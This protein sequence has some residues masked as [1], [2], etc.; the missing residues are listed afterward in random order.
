M[1]IACQLEKTQVKNMTPEFSRGTATLRIIGD[2]IKNFYIINFNILSSWDMSNKLKISFN[3]TSK[4]DTTIDFAI[5]KPNYYRLELVRPDKRK[6]YWVN[7]FLQQNEITEVIVKESDSEP[8][9]EFGG[10]LAPI[11]DYLLKKDISTSKNRQPLILS[12]MSKLADWADYDSA[13]IKGLNA[14]LLFLKNYPSFNVLPQWFQQ[15]ER[16]Q[17]IYSYAQ[18]KLTYVFWKLELPPDELNFLDTMV[19]NNPDAVLSDTYYHFLRSYFYF[20][21]AKVW[22][23]RIQDYFSLSHDEKMNAQK[24]YVI[25]THEIN[26][27]ILDSLEKE[28]FTGGLKLAKDKLSNDIMTKLAYFTSMTD[29]Y[30]IPTPSHPAVNSY[31]FY[32]EN[33]KNHLFDSL[34]SGMAA[35]KFNLMEGEKIEFNN[36]LNE[37]SEGIKISQLKGKV[38]LLNFWFPGCRPCIESIPD[39]VELVKEFKDKDF[40]LVSIGTRA[41]KDACF[42]FAKEYNMPGL[43]LFAEYNR[44][45]VE[46]YDLVSY[47]KFILIDKGGRIMNLKPPRPGNQELNKMIKL[48]L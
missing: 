28:H 23:Q 10:S 41:D 43:L 31:Q 14:E 13:L 12:P 36:F 3:C 17:I 29:L 34:L 37:R 42:K 39:E 9:I 35:K 15:L 11:N 21:T 25:G 16:N 33:F 46:S 47:P 27:L 8:K 20:Q 26:Q 22:S 48:Y 5:I 45:L 4:T 1:L 40:I 2:S 18:Q 7:I 19:I 44:S 32:S 6:N 24:N 38:V 30:L